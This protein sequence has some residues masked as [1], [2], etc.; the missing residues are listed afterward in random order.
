MTASQSELGGNLIKSKL[1]KRDNDTKSKD[2]QSSLD[3]HVS[4]MFKKRK[5]Q[6]NN[7]EPLII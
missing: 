7:N 3:M 6:R 5:H 4:T 2:S 1:R